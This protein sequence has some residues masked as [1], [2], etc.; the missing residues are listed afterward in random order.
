MELRR[1]PLALFRPSLGLQSWRKETVCSEVAKV[2]L[3]P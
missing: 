2:P 3:P 1:C